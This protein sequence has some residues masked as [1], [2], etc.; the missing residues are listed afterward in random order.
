MKAN[1]DA[2][3]KVSTSISSTYKKEWNKLKP[4]MLVGV[5]ELNT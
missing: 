1:M 3:I 4:L 2:N 5:C